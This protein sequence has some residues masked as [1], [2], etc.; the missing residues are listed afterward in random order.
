MHQPTSASFCTW[1]GKELLFV[2]EHLN[3]FLE[4]HILFSLLSSRHISLVNGYFCYRI[5]SLLGSLSFLHHALFCDSFLFFSFSLANCAPHIN[6]S[7]YL[8]QSHPASTFYCNTFTHRAFPLPL[9]AH[10]SL[11]KKNSPFLLCCSSPFAPYAPP[12]IDLTHSTS[13]SDL[14]AC[15]RNAI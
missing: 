13:C 7:I 12:F 14:L 15:M 2:M 6:L 11:K 9:L 1:Y 10:C 4:N 5:V 3:I 8:S